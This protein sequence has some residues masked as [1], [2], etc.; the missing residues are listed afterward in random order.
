MIK[1]EEIKNKA[2][3][4]RYFLKWWLMFLLL[5]IF[6]GFCLYN[7]IF[8]SIWNNDVTKLSFFI[9][10]LFVVQTGVCGI[11]T[12]RAGSGADNEIRDRIEA[13]W[14]MS[15]LFLSIGMVGTVI[16]FISMLAG[17]STLSIEDV[18][19]VQEL[20]KDLGF[21]MST[22]LYTTL[23]GLISSVFLKI[24]YFNLEQCVRKDEKII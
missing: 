15:D 19:T 1:I 12:F 8:I 13:G 7:D 17:F 5:T 20:I 4:H 23:V 14:F 3:K 16:G 6:S 9:I 18:S 11:N 10:F 22:A 21:G 24:Q 2:I